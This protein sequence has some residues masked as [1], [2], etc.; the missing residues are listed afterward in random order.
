MDPILVI[1]AQNS[2]LLRKS[3]DDRFRFTLPKPK[4]HCNF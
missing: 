4:S 3:Q 1:D 2:S